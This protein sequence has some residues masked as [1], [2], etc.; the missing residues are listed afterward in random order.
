MGRDAADPPMNTAGALVREAAALLRAHGVAEPV[1]DAERLLGHVLG[2]DRAALHGDPARP[3]SGTQDEQFRSLARRRAAREPLQHLTGEQEFW[4]L[5]FR[6]TPDVL[7]PRPESEHLIEALLRL[8]L[9]PDPS[10]LDVGTGSGCL[11]IAA[12]REIP[13]ALVVATDIEAAAL[14]VARGNALRHGVS[15]RVTFLRGDLFAPLS[16][17][18]Q[19]RGFDV[20]L[21]NPPYIPEA[22][23]AGLEPEVRDHEPRRALTPGP[24]GLAVHRRL[25]AAALDWLRP[26]GTL[27]VEIGAGQDE[28]ARTLYPAGGGL[29][30][31]A[32]EPDLAGIP[33]VIVARAR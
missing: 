11:A 14:D 24:D 30:L 29:D 12:A 22:E 3:I 27:L 13:G 2:L 20:I 16:G 8:G 33:R 32:I 18:R 4:S 15:D 21:C 5:S 10:L 28:A 6:V 25:A 1:R 31:T 9:R 7:V 23:M 26:G 19:E 17:R